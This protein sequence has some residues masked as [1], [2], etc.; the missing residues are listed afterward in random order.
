MRLYAVDERPCGPRTETGN[1]VETEPQ[2][3]YE[4]FVECNLDVADLSEA[5]LRGADLSGAKL[6]EA[7]LARANLYDVDLS[8]ATLRA[9]ACMRL[10][11]LGLTSIEP[12]WRRSICAGRL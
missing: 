4:A 11:C 8:G 10:T 5:N 7:N 6:E 2:V 3:C 9:P 1:A 12:T